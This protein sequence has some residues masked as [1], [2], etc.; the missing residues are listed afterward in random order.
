MS[1]GPGAAD[2][3]HMEF[4]ELSVQE[5]YGYRRRKRAVDHETYP[6]DAAAITGILRNR[7]I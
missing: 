3:R 1:L 5:L 6:A 4:W 7:D 2:V